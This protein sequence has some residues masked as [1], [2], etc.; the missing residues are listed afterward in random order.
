MN[1]Q[2]ESNPLVVFMDWYVQAIDSSPMQH[3]SQVCLSTI[4]ERGFPDGRF[5]DVKQVNEKGIIFC[6]NFDSNKAN[7][8]RQCNKV[9]LTF[10]WEHVFRQV[11]IKGLATPISHDLADS[12]WK[13][14]NR[15]A[16]ITWYASKQSAKLPSFEAMHAMVTE[17][18]A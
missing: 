9:A 10:W 12:F 1:L 14:R 11:R 6:T 4:D 18:S 13:A 5:V 3:E 7:A 2:H 16:Q 15:D 8:I 17:A